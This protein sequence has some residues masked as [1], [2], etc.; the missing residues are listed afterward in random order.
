M[1]LSQ[2][3]DGKIRFN[4]Q[5]ENS[6]AYVIPFIEETFAIH[7]GM[8][9]MEIGCGEGG[10]L[11]PFLERGCSCVGVDL[12]PARIALAETYLGGFRDTGRLRLISK[13]IYDLDFLGEFRGYFDLILL[14]DAIEHIPDQERIMGYLPGLLRENGRVF[15]GFPPWFMPHGGHQ[16]ICQ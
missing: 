16:Q 1:T 13:N 14:K 11:Q 8:R 7:P 4:Q 5:V 10:V 3:I 12:E 15:L 2:H 9:V 6:A